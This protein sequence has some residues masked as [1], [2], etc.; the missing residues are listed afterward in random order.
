MKPAL[1]FCTTSLLCCMVWLS[2]CSRRLSTHAGSH[3]ALAEASI[4]TFNMRCDVPENDSSNNWAHR[5]HRIAHF[6]DSLAID[7]V[8]SQELTGSQDSTLLC[9]MPRYG[10]VRTSYDGV[11]AI[12]Y[13]RASIEVVA[14]GC[15]SLSESPDSIM[16]KGWD[17]AYP[18]RAVWAVMRHRASGKQFV[19][20]NTHL[21]HIGAESRREGAKL[22]VQRLSA[23]T[24]G[25]PVVVTGD[26]N[27]ENDSEAYAILTSGGLCDAQKTAQSASGA[28]YTWHNYGRLDATQRTIIDFV[29][30]S[31]HITAK[32]CHIP[33]PVAGAMLSDH[34]PLITTITF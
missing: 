13:R 23:I 8:A 33:H 26:F 17:A 18:R 6:I 15:F 2:S 20:I 3:T 21:D 4:A 22:I 34:S 19:V 9:L 1:C 25:L 29:F 24:R 14:Q 7:V 11:N 27:A 12:F 32:H 16:K 5:R 30:I 28:T 10:E 31:P